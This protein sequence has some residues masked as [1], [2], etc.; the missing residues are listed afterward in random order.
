MAHP[1]SRTRTY[2]SWTNMRDRCLNPRNPRYDDYG[3]RGIRICKRWLTF[4]NFLADMGTRPANTTIGRINN[5]KG[6]YPA[7]CRWETK[8]EQY[9]NM[10]SNHFVSWN[11]ETKSIGA[12]ARLLG[13]KQNTLLY[14]I[15]RGWRIERVMEARILSKAEALVNARTARLTAGGDR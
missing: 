5:D 1:K 15:R 13:V 12:W 9:G 6:Y 4:E 14:R 10:R 11:G 3:G 2:S 8:A 7:N